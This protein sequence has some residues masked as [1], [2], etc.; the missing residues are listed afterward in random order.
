MRINKAWRWIFV[1][2]WM[3]VIF[4]FSH[5][6]NSG[7]ESEKYLGSFNVPV[8]KFGHVSEYMILFLLLRWS[9]NPEGAT[10]SDGTDKLK[11]TILSPSILA[12]V[13]SILY[14]ASD[15]WHQSYVP[16]RSASWTDVMVD[17]CGIALGGGVCWIGLRGKRTK[18]DEHSFDNSTAG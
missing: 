10:A 2:V 12:L 11:R 15:E 5:Q 4:A 7:R 17:V 8:R 14:A 3:V 16:G 6:A 1:I 9:L 18:S 13:L